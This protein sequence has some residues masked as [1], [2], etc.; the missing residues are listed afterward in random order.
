MGRPWLRLLDCVLTI[1]AAGYGVRVDDLPPLLVC[2]RPP[3]HDGPHHDV[4][5][6]VA[7][8]EPAS[9]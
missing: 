2:G 7:W 6:A 8:K 5:W 1:C 3:G 9:G 4:Q